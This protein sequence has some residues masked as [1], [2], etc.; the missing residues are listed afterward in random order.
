MDYIPEGTNWEAEVYGLD[1]YPEF[2]GPSV[3]RQFNTN[4][5]NI[6]PGPERL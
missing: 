4:F 5:E 3:P 6:K 2:W 1:A